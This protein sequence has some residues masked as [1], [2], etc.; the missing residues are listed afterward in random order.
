M[1]TRPVTPSTMRTTSGDSSRKGMQSMTRTAPC[2]VLNVVS[3][4][5]VSPR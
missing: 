5:S 4:T 2:A 1:S 3:S